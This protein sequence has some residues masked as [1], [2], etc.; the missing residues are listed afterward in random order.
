M[1]KTKPRGYASYSTTLQYSRSFGGRPWNIQA[2]LSPKYLRHKFH[3]ALCYF[4]L[5]LWWYKVKNNPRGSRDYR[6]K[7]LEI[8]RRVFTGEEG[9]WRRKAAA[10][11]AGDEKE[12]GDRSSP[13]SDYYGDSFVAYWG[14]RREILSVI[15]RVARRGSIQIA[16]D[17]PSIGALRLFLFVLEF[18]S[19]DFI[20]VLG[21]VREPQ[22]PQLI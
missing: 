11:L 16:A 6:N 17:L 12:K 22:I 2:C 21:L 20:E 9:W 8:F 7:V 18:R 4:S 10:K 5:N 1:I 19:G 13:Q 14:W 15:G 3:R